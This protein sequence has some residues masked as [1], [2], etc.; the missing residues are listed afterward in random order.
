VLSLGYQRVN[1]WGN[2][3]I[4]DNISHKK[5][6]LSDGFFRIRRIAY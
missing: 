2:R 5:T 6:A 4:R 1:E 3:T